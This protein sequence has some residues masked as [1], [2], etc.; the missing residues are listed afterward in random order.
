MKYRI[1]ALALILAAALLLAGCGETG[2]GTAP[3]VPAGDAQYAEATDAPAT[4]EA[5]APAEPFGVP[6][7]EAPAENTPDP[8]P[9]EAEAPVEGNAPAP[10]TEAEEEHIDL[11]ERAVFALC[12]AA[13][14]GMR[15]DPWDPIFFWRSMG[16]LMV[17][18]AESIPDVTLEPTDDLDL[19][20]IPAE[21]LDLFIQALF[22]NFEG[23]IPSLGEENPLVMWEST[24]AG[25]FYLVPVRDFSDVT[26]ELGEIVS[27]EAGTYYTEATLY[28]DG[29]ALGTW[30]VNME[31][32]RS[33][34]GEVHIFDK[35]IYWIEELKD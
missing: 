5:P 4:A 16:Y 12:F 17:E 7:T 35:N 30:S 8:A 34:P 6:E 25:E 13:S 32:Y 26:L 22:G 3:P 15:Y 18:T 31:D 27:Y 23:Q 29:K 1:Y 33:I 10:V 20:R 2:S 24:E 19:L 21:H 9:A 14:E 28:R 11:T